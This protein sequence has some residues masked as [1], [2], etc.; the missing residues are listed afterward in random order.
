M[1]LVW[2]Y[3]VTVV[4]QN[5]TKATLFVWRSPTFLAR[6]A[7]V[8]RGTPEKTLYDTWGRFEF[9]FRRLGQG[10]LRSVGSIY[11]SIL[12]HYSTL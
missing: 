1:C 4:P 8:L 11:Y 7:Y 3:V 5:D 12:S 10:N 6:V 2:L 9:L